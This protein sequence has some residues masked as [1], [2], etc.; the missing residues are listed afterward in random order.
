M[1]QNA[2]KGATGHTKLMTAKWMNTMSP[3]EQ[4]YMASMGESATKIK[5]KMWDE[6][7][8]TKVEESEEGPIDGY[9]PNDSDLNNQLFFG[10]EE[11]DGEYVAELLR[12]KA[13][14]QASAGL[15]KVTDEPKLEDNAEKP[16]KKKKD[17]KEKK[18][19]QEDSAVGSTNTGDQNSDKAL[20]DHNSNSKA[21][22]KETSAKKKTKPKK[23]D[24]IAIDSGS[25]SKVTINNST[26][27]V[28]KPD[29][30]KSKGKAKDV[31][32]SKPSKDIV[33]DGVFFEDDISDDE[34]MIIETIQL[35]GKAVVDGG[36]AGN[37]VGGMKPGNK[38]ENKNAKKEKAAMLQKSTK[39]P[40]Q[41]ITE[42]DLALVHWGS[43]LKLCSLLVD[44]LQKLHFENP[45][46]IQQAAIPVT[47]TTECD[48]VGMAETGSGKVRKLKYQIVHLPVRL[49]LI[50]CL[51]SPFL[52]D[53]GLRS[54][55]FRHFAS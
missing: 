13:L 2:S 50:I 20:A 22:A 7:P 16:K 53:A 47:S 6:L 28:V 23:V 26:Q 44:S 30:D 45:T 25:S 43:K 52:L 14:A 12:K 15:A 51:L 10:I 35:G 24:E 31:K 1:R 29:S 38:N 46:P 48:V 32:K 37:K 55:H 19:R 36:A 4:L 9:D 41:D 21:A 18:K 3:V 5:G 8:W 34:G 33:D 42:S 40:V 39:A 49:V 17:K 11:V 27:Q 54:T